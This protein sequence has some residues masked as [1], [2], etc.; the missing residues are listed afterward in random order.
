MIREE[1]Y[2]KKAIIEAQKALEIEEVPIGAVVVY[3]EQIVGRGYNL[4]ERDHDPTAHAEIIALRDAARNMQSWRLDQCELYVTIEPCPMCAGA[5]VQA[6]IKKLVYG[7]KDIKAGG[8]SSLYN[9]CSDERLNHF[10][11]EIKGEVLT[12]ECSTL[13]KDFFKKLRSK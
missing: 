4:K 8:V 2:M 6:R 5:I 13:M 3:K 9:I 7:A 12:E 10:V 11:P 1:K